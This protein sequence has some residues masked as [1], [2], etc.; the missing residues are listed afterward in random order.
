M[1]SEKKSAPRV[2]ICIPCYRQPALLLRALESV[3][4]QTFMDFEV[5]ISDDSPSDEC[6]IVV[7]E[8]CGEDP[9]FKYFHNTSPLGSPENWNRTLDLASGDLI[10]I[11]HHDD[12]FFDSDSLDILVK[13][14]D[15]D[16][17]AVM[18]FGVSVNCNANGE[19]TGI[20]RPAALDL[21]RMQKDASYL[22]KG[23]FIGA[24]SAMIFRASP[25]LRF[26][27]RLRW[28]VDVDFYIRLMSA[29]GKRLQFIDRGVVNITTGSQ[30]Q[31]TAECT[32]VFGVEVR[33]ALYLLKKLTAEG[34]R[35][36][37]ISTAY[38]DLFDRFKIDSFHV[39]RTLG[40]EYDEKDCLSVVAARNW[41]LAVD[42]Y[43]K[44]GG[45][46]LNPR[47]WL[48]ILAKYLLFVRKLLFG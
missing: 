7:K 41:Y 45:S 20:P 4:I 1:S 24:P 9:R 2:S 16:P 46:L 42:R 27:R 47:F 14:M 11:L 5:I 12:Q 39:I 33:E 15:A 13:A 34:I 44:I 43:L 10:K 26:D 37:Y 38:W 25:T 22:L 17:Q 31:V 19:V 6:K 48:K 35:S 29:T 23:N 30:L 40:W 32:D 8:F 36:R 18:A 28:L 21:H 3:R